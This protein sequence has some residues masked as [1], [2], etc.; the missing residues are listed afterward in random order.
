MSLSAGTHVADRIYYD[1]P[2]CMEFS[3]EVTAIREVARVDGKQVWQIALDRTA[4]YPSSGGQPFDTGTLI[5]TARSGA[6]LSVPIAEVTEDEAGEVWH[7]TQKPLQE[8]TVVRCHVDTA[9]RRDHMQQHSG[10]HLLSAVLDRDLGART[11]SFHLGPQQCTIDIV[12]ESLSDEALSQVESTVNEVVTE[13]LPI[14]IRFISQ[15]EAETMLAAGLLRKL[16]PRSGRIR[17]I[18]IPGLDL[19]ACG[20]THVS[21]T[22]QIGPVLLRGTERVRDAIRLRFVCGHRALRAAG[23]D[24]Q[25]LSSLARSLSTGAGEI[26]A[27]VARL[28]VEIRATQKERELLLQALAGVEAL[29]VQAAGGSIDGKLVIHTLDPLQPGRDAVY[30]KLLAARLVKDTPAQMALVVLPQADR[31]AVVLAA[32]PGEIDC[33]S[34]LRAVLADLGGRGGG[35]RE[36]AQG[37]LP[38]PELAMFLKTLPDRFVH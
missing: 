32:K 36:I 23:D 10:Q 19:N 38:T 17:L 16:P 12:A 29:A 22:A 14:S 24:F 30:T 2:L 9:R 8:G 13:A 15:E 31:C 27:T 20:G 5:A 4:F 37:S 35:S 33:G 34:V 21:T 1:E 3:A 18:E 7:T 11:I 26:A 28:Q 6:S 25:Q